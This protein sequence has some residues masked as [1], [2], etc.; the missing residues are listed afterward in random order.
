MTY[1]VSSGTLSLY[2]TNTTRHWHVCYIK[3]RVL[4]SIHANGGFTVGTLHTAGTL[5]KV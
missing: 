1:N 2:T 5:Q 4:Y 3:P